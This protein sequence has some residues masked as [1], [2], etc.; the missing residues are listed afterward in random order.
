M[1]GLATFEFDTSIFVA[2]GHDRVSWG[3]TVFARNIEVTGY[4][5][6][7]PEDGN[8]YPVSFD[9][10]GLQYYYEVHVWTDQ[11]EIVVWSGDPRHLDT[12]VKRSTMRPRNQSELLEALETIGADFED[13][14]DTHIAA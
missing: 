12:F 13:W 8:V 4:P 3:P 6:T 14:Y 5:L 10:E 1:S 11:V 7:D 2:Y 9:V